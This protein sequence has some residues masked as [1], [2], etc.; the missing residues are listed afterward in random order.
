MFRG[1]FLGEKQIFP[2]IFRGQISP[3]ERILAIRF[4]SG[5]DFKQVKN[6]LQGLRGNLYPMGV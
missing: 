5:I 2:V 1:R 6:H 3:C 4:S